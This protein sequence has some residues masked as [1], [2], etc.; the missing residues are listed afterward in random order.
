MGIQLA[1]ELAAAATT[2]KVL[3]S[4]KTGG[5][6]WTDAQY[7]QA[8]TEL[9]LAPISKDLAVATVKKKST[10]RKSRVAITEEQ[11]LKVLGEDEVSQG[12]I[13]EKLETTAVTVKKK[14]DELAKAKKVSSRKVGVAVMWKVK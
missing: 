7:G 14:L 8:L 3:A 12:K 10:T 4:I 1:R 6:V 13:A 9:N 11:I 5:D 2:Y